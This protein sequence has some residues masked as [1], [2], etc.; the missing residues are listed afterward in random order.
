MNR[1]RTL[2]S[3][4]LWVLALA[5][6]LGLRVLPVS[7]AD[8]Q[9]VAHNTPRYVAAAAYVKPEDPT[10]LID[11]TLWL[12]PHN[13]EEMDALAR[14][15]YDPGSPNYRHWLTRTQIAARFAPTADEAAT[16]S[17]F[18]EA[19]HLKVVLVGDGNYF[20]RARGTVADV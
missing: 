12:N 3:Q 19:Q 1:G 6:L 18:F 4:S 2:K 11:V 15:L 14:D 10:T 9:L 17:T 5:A 16:V 8:G 20:V 7:A 13:R